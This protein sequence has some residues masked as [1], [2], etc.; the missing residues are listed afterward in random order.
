MGPATS[1]ADKAKQRRLKRSQTI[2]Q[3]IKESDTFVS[4]E[5]LKHMFNGFARVIEFGTVFVDKKCNYNPTVDHTQNYIISMTEGQ[6]QNGLISGFSRSHDSEGECKVGFWK[7]HLS[8]EKF[9]YVSRPYG[10]FAHY[11]KD[12]SFKTPDGLYF[13]NDRVWN[14]IVRPQQNK[15]FITN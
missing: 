9:T 15:D 2:T 11:Y 4:K 14:K 1:L 10:K 12:G 8:N 6:L 5:D 7:T 3:F 13:G